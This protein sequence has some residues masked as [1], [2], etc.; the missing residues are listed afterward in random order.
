MQ[1]VWTI[2]LRLLRYVAAIAE[3]GTITAAAER[4]GLAQPP[5]TRQIRDLEGRLGVTLFERHPRGVTLTEAG[6]VFVAEARAVL[7]RAEGIAGAAQRA[8]RGEAGRLAVG[9]TSSA[10][11]NPLVTRAIRAYRA[12]FPAVALSLEE[13]GTPDL[14]A[15]LKAGRLD[16]AFSRSALGETAGVELTPLLDEP[17]V[18]VLPTDHTLAAAPNLPLTALAAET[19]ILY[20]RPLGPGLYDGVISACRA[21]G[22]SPHVGQE[23]PRMPSTLSL[24]AAGLG[25]SIVPASMR[26]LNLDGLAYIDLIADPPLTA[27]LLLATRAQGDPAAARFAEVVTAQTK[28]PAGE[29]GRSSVLKD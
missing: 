14:I 22:F 10:A 20:R 4:L 13:D 27:P 17:M 9:Y 29:G 12:A 2:E 26:R 8:A 19:F 23:A 5:L 1:R 3:A 24:V 18:A 6:E 25:V 16:A 7:E 11:F 28:T 21:A 15:A